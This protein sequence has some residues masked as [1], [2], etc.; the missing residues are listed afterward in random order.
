MSGRGRKASLPPADHAR[1]EPLG[2]DGL[3]VHHYNK[4]GRVKDYDFAT[5]PVAEPLQRSLAVLFAACCRPNHWTSHLSSRQPWNYL[6]AFTKYLSEQHQPPRDLDELTGTLIDRWWEHKGKTAGGRS[7]FRSVCAMLR[8]DARL[9]SGTVADALARRIPA[10]KSTTQSYGTKEFDQIRAAARRMFRAALLRI[11]ENALQLDRWRAGEFEEGSRDWII[12][13]ALDI[14]ARTGE[15]PYLVGPT[16]KGNLVKKY[17]RALGGQATELTWQR[18]FLSRTEATALAVLLLAEYGW[19]LSVINRAVVP[20]ATP[21]PGLDGCP[22]YRIPVEKRRRGGGSWYATENVTDHGADSPGR[23]ITQALQATRFARAIVEDMAPGTDLL[24]VFR[25]GRRGR[26]TM[27]QETTDKDYHPHV[28]PFAFTLASRN[29]YEWAKLAGLRGSPFRRGRRTAVAV[30]RR[31]PTQHSQESHD[32]DYVLP[33]KQVQDAAVPVIAAAAEAAALRARET[34]LVAEMRDTRNP[35]DVETATADCSDFDNGP[36]SSPDG[37]CG[38]SFLMC[39]ACTNARVHADHHPRLAHL[40][41]ALTSVR[42]VLP[43][44]RWE[45]DWSD[46]HARLTDLK[47]KIGPGG[48]QRALARVTSADRELIHLLLTGDLDA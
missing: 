36:Y 3:V 8:D 40:H 47:K 25:V 39:L 6:K 37:G 23:L 7:A 29:G 9:Q 16:G 1:P 17:R 12:G 35:D 11:E 42:S 26:D 5:L 31:E 28:G 24:I 21:D 27:D 48:W 18:L 30:N 43:P 15:L 4:A 20:K 19:N 22:T 41:E 38:A 34:V 33:D 45:R 44:P 10:S 13:E 32:R 14:L 2:P 46:P